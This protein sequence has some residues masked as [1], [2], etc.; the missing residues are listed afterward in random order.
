MTPS[1]FDDYL[2]EWFCTVNRW[3]SIAEVTRIQKVEV[4]QFADPEQARRVLLNSDA[5]L[6]CLLLAS[7]RSTTS[8]GE[9][10]RHLAFGRTLETQ[11]RVRQRIAHKIEVLGQYGL[12]DVIQRT[13]KTNSYRISA[14]DFLMEVLHE[15]YEA[16]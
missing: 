2:D 4:E 6:V 15:I 16:T 14:S 12:L 7:T 10:A 1:S 3:H 13:G 11:K 9:L 5:M 8:V